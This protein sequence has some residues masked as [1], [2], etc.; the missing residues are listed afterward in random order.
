MNSYHRVDSG[1]ETNKLNH[2]LFVPSKMVQASKGFDEIEA[3][4]NYPE[5]LVICL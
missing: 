2:L 3:F 1:D 4:V 5:E